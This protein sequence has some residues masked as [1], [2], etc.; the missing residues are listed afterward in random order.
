MQRSEI[1][2][3]NITVNWSSKVRDILNHSGFGDVW[4]FPESINIDKFIPLL[5]IRLRDQYVAE[6]RT[7]IDSS[8]SLNMYKESKP[9]IERSA[10]LDL[11][12]NKK[13]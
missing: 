12:E 6:W 1:V 7:N 4:L 2:K 13:T 9:S 10:Y 5:K 3:R 8:T 11:I